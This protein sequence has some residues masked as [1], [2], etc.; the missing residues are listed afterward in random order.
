MLTSRSISSCHRILQKPSVLIFSLFMRI[1]GT[2]FFLTGNLTAM[3]PL[4]QN[5]VTNGLIFKMV[6]KILIVDYA[7]RLY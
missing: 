5:N 6:T 4:P 1:R 2:E 7:R 3:E